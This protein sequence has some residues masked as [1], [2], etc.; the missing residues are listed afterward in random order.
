LVDFADELTVIVVA[1][2]KLCFLKLMKIGC[3]SRF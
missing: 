1:F 2:H 3:P